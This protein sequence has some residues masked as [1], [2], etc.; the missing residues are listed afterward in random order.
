M[1][2]ATEPYWNFIV[3]LNKRSARFLI[4]VQTRQFQ[5][6][7]NFLL[8]WHCKRT[9][10]VKTNVLDFVYKYRICTYSFA[11]M[12]DPLMVYWPDIHEVSNFCIF[13][14]YTHCLIN[15]I[16][17]WKHYVQHWTLSVLTKGN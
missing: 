12:I 1:V 3:W 6:V 15:K 4:Y 5:T 13:Y 16:E 8:L 14:K 2:S 10:W 11:K 9:D 7:Y 17:V